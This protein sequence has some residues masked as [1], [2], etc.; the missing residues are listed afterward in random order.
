MRKA[1]PVVSQHRGEQ[2]LPATTQLAIAILGPLTFWDRTPLLSMSIMIERAK[3]RHKRDTDKFLTL[4]KA[5]TW[6]LWGINQASY[7]Y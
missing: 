3:A 2:N 6:S 4:K 1:G 5:H 7:R